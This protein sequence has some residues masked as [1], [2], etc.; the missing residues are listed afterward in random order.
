MDRNALLASIQSGKSLKKVVTNDRSGVRG[1]GGVIGQPGEKP[2]PEAADTS[3]PDL[4]S[5]KA[6]LSG[7]FGG[8]PSSG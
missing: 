6:Q 1:A 7:M 4:K 2:T 8:P 5:L 3:A